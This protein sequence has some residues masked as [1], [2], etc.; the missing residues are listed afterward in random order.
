MNCHTQ[1]SLGPVGPAR[2]APPRRRPRRQRE[3]AGTE[4]PVAVEAGQGHIYEK[5]VFSRDPSAKYRGPPL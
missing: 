1:H 5:K 3:R 4:R 2:P